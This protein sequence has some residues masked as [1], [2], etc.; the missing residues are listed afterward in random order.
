MIT[1]SNLFTKASIFD[2]NKY[3][4]GFMGI[5]DVADDDGASVSGGSVSGD[6]GTTGTRQVC[7]CLTIGSFLTIKNKL[8]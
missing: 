1:Y 3:R 6:T 7:C 2:N 4:E 5:P 8:N